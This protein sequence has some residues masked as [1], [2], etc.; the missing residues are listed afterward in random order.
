[1]S[2]IRP[3]PTPP[4]HTLSTQ[5]VIANFPLRL[6]VIG[7]FVTGVVFFLSYVTFLSRL[8]LDGGGEGKI[9]HLPQPGNPNGYCCVC[10]GIYSRLAIGEAASAICLASASHLHASD[11]IIFF[12]QDVSKKWHL[13]EGLMT[14][15]YQGELSRRGALSPTPPLD[16]APVVV[17]HLRGVRVG[18]CERS[19]PEVPRSPMGRYAIVSLLR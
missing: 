8:L 7:Y 2:V 10:I 12:R 18:S 13:V 15:A 11:L 6:P 4:H 9:K 17:F 3:P 16:N 19:E 5:I 1:M 14:F